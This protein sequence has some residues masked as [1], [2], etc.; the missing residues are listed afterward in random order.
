MTAIFKK[1][2]IATDFLPT[3]VP[4]GNFKKVII[5]RKETEKGEHTYPG[6]IHVKAKT[7]MLNSEGDYALYLHK[8]S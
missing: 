8:T 5:L 1:N 4:D 6:K 2:L 7:S 3:Q